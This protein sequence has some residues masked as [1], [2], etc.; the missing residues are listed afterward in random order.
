MRN[1]NNEGKQMTVVNTDAP[2]AKSKWETL[3]WESI[4]IEVKRLQMRIAKA[5]R[6]GKHRKAGLYSGC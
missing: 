4:E 2:S 6:D 1:R 3:S 5:T